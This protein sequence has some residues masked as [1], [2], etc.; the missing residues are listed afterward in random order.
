MDPNEAIE[1]ESQISL[2]IRQ[3]NDNIIGNVMHRCGL[4]VT[5]GHLSTHVAEE[6]EEMVANVRPIVQKYLRA[7]THSGL[8]RRVG[9]RYVSNLPNDDGEPVPTELAR[10]SSRSPRRRRRVG[11]EKEDQGG[12]DSEGEMED[13]QSV[14]GG[15]Q[16][17]KRAASRSRSRSRTTRSRSRSTKRKSGRRG[18][19]KSPA[20]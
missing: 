15:V 5:V 12:V 14:R 6:C 4:P 17:K 11:Q 13:S 2:D 19:A 9:R 3:Q 1:S 16:R 10:A 20:K 18:K 8:V 7:G